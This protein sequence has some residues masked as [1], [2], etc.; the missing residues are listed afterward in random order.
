M[1][2]ISLY[3][4]F[5]AATAVLVVIPGPNVALVVAN[6]VVYGRRLGLVTVAGTTAAA[7]LPQ[8]AF[9][10]LGMTGSLLL[11]DRFF[12]WVRWAGVA[13]LVYLGV[14][15]WR[16]PVLDLTRVMP[17]SR[18]AR[19]IFARGMLVSLTNPKSLLFYGAF[20]PQFITPGPNLL[21][22]MLLLS[23]TFLIIV[24]VHDS[25][26]ALAAGWL[27]P[28]LAARGSLRNRLTGGF[29]LAAAVGLTAAGAT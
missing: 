27:R 12:E 2:P 29:Y 19:A 28:L 8:L 4:A 18:S 15:A 1:P 23:A 13:Y 5:V 14:T 21:G 6:S 22:Q 7:M 17:E 16:A 9:I 25:C 24:A 11:A 26:W 20:F 10:M 3:L